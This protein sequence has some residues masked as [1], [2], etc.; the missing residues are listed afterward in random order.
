[1]DNYFDI[2]DLKKKI[3]LTPSDKVLI[4]Q[5]IGFNYVMKYLKVVETELGQCM[6]ILPS[7][8]FQP[9]QWLAIGPKGSVP[10]S[11][12]IGTPLPSFG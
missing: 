9:G 11:I 3:A 4:M 6:R 10:P 5:T 7:L 2:G 12:S 1:M 8:L